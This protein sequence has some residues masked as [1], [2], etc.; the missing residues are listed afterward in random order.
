[1]MCCF[2]KVG[3]GLAM[4]LFACAV[5]AVPFPCPNADESFR[6]GSKVQTILTHGL[7]PTKVTYPTVTS[8]NTDAAEGITDPLIVLD[9]A[10]A[11]LPFLASV[12]WDDPECFSFLESPTGS[13][14]DNP[15]TELTDPEKLYEE[16]GRSFAASYVIARTEDADDVANYVALSTPSWNNSYY[17]NVRNL[18]DDNCGGVFQKVTQTVGQGEIISG[19]STCVTLDSDFVTAFNALPTG[20]L[21]ADTVPTYVEFCNQFGY[22]FPTRFILQSEITRLIDGTT[23]YS[24]GQAG[25]SNF[26]NE[27]C[28]DPDVGGLVLSGWDELISVYDNNGVLNTDVAN[29]FAVFYE[30]YPVSDV[31][32]P[33]VQQLKQ[34]QLF[35]YAVP[36]ACDAGGNGPTAPSPQNPMPSPTAVMPTSGGDGMSWSRLVIVSGGLWI[37]GA[38]SL[39]I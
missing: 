37:G 38:V 6:P 12:S 3:G 30:T 23:T 19:S 9:T 14:D 7:S 5:R 24:F 13:R 18:L 4:L 16:F 29:N 2:E 17:N 15:L 1:M 27:T 39:W 35:T 34:E 36:E 32:L 8:S 28:Q 10:I 25:V 21:D 11:S 33:S 22:R 26:T 31:A 20:Q